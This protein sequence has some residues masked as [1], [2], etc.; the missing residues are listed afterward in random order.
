MQGVQL[1]SL[2]IEGSQYVINSRQAYDDD[3][4]SYNRGQSCNVRL[5]GPV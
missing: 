1:H 3:L 5:A 2:S 4:L